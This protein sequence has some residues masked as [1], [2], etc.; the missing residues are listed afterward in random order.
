M[1][2]SQDIITGG[3]LRRMIAGAYGAF[4][5][6]HEY[7][8]SLNVFPVPDGDTGTNM[9]CG[10]EQSVPAS[11]AFARINREKGQHIVLRSGTLTNQSPC[12][13]VDAKLR[14]T[15]VGFEYR[16]GGRGRPVKDSATLEACQNGLCQ[17]YVTVQG[18]VNLVVE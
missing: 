17:C 6:G 11:N 18:R 1:R 14:G 15:L 10:S 8:N 9:L 4:T 5:R 12:G 13:C 7:I 16:R 3:D 2:L